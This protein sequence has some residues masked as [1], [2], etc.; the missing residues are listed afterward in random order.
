MAGVDGERRHHRQEHTLEV[1]LEVSRLLGVLPAGPNKV[2][3]L[4]GE[5]RLQDLEEA[6]VLVL[7][8]PVDLDGHRHHRLPG[9]EPVRTDR[10]VAGGDETLEAG[11]PHHEEL[12]QV[13]AEDRKELDPLE[14]RHRFVLGFLEHA[15]VELEP[16]QLAIDQRVIVRH[17]RA[18]LSVSRNS[19]P[20]R[21]PRVETTKD[22]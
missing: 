10:L 19:K 11:H 18:P 5:A 14:E 21:T 9:G 12:V 15:A 17:H 16:R 22:R 20:S 8:E 6:A 2:N 13:R 4:G 1:V 3:A 7:D